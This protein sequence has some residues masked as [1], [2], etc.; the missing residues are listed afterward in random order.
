MICTFKMLL[1][2]RFPRKQAFLDDFPL[3]PQRPPPPPKQTFYFYCRLAVSDSTRCEMRFFPRE[4]GKMAFVEGFSLKRPFS[5]SRVRKNRISQGVENPG[6]LISVP[7]ALRDTIAHHQIDSG[8]GGPESF[9]P[10]ASP[11]RLIPM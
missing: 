9:L 8:K 1:S 5:L 10:E 11:C 3:C 4:K 6:S 2:W 7:L